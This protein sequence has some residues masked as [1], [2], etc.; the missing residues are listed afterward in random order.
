MTRVTFPN[1]V[2][3]RY[4]MRCED[5]E[6]DALARTPESS[7]SNWWPMWCLGGA[8]VNAGEYEQWRRK[9]RGDVRIKRVLS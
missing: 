6:V 8:L 5:G 4:V 1:T 3:P 2:H 9:Q 7:Y